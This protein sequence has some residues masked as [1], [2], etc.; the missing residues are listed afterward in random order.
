MPN[1]NGRFV[2]VGHT[3]IARYGVDKVAVEVPEVEEVPAKRVTRKRKGKVVETAAL[4]PVV[5]SGE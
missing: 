4:K 2:P 1:V 5:E 3:D